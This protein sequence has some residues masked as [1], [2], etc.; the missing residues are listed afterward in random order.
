MYTLYG[1]PSSAKLL[2]NFAQICVKDEKFCLEYSY[3]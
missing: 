2:L 1:C 3:Q